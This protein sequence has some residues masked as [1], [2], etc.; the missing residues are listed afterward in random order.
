MKD[1]MKKG[2]LSEKGEQ[3]KATSEKAAQKPTSEKK[4]EAKHEEDSKKM[5]SCGCKYY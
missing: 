5:A 2:L 1:N 3:Q 4:H